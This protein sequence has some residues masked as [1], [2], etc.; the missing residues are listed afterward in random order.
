MAT[1]REK[2]LQG[3]LYHS[4]EPE[5]GAMRHRAQSDRIAS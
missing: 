4:A 3:K 1:E 5:L 2:M